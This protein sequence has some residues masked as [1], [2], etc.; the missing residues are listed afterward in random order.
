MGRVNLE[1]ICMHNYAISGYY[2]ILGGSTFVLVRFGMEL[3]YIM[4]IENRH[5][6]HV[7]I[8]CH[9]PIFHILPTKSPKE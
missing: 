4:R 8:M 6:H 5:H 7:G 3:Y 9:Q 2:F 1:S